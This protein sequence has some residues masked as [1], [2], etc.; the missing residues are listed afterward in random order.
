MNTKTRVPLEGQ[1]PSQNLTLLRGQFL[2]RSVKLHKHQMR[3]MSDSLYPVDITVYIIKYVKIMIL[4]K[5]QQTVRTPNI[6]TNSSLLIVI[7]LSSYIDLFRP[8]N[9]VDTIHPNDVVS[10]H[11][12]RR[13]HHY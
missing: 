3:N 10:I 4:S 5:L 7:T 1:D 2:T 9:D 8:S 12:K 13:S 6:L 11:P